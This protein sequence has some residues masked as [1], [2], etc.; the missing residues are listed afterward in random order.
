MSAHRTAKRRARLERLY[1]QP[2]EKLGP[3]QIE[4]GQWC[5]VRDKWGLKKW[6][7]FGQGRSGKVVKIA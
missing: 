6:P 4:L 1:A 3:R 7:G 5:A 2:T